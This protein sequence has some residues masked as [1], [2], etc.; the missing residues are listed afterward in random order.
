MAW[1][2]TIRCGLENL[3]LKKEG[4]I[5]AYVFKSNSLSALLEPHK[6]CSETE[7]GFRK[8]VLPVAYGKRAFQWRKF[9]F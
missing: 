8:R 7:V 9:R 6:L 5:A 2:Y 1:R 4:A 3:V